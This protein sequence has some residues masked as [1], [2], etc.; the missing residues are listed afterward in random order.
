MKTMV[1]TMILL[2][3]VASAS[4]AQQQGP[5]SDHW[6][7]ISRASSIHVIDSADLKIHVPDME[8]KVRDRSYYYQ[9]SVE[10]TLK[11]ERVDSIKIRMVLEQAFIDRVKSLPDDTGLIIFITNRYAEF[12]NSDADE[13]SNFFLGTIDNKGIIIRTDEVYRGIVDEIRSQRV[14]LHDKLYESFLRDEDMDRKIK[15]LIGELV[16]PEREMAAFDELLKIGK[17]AV[18]YIILH[19]D[20]YRELPI[21]YAMVIDDSPDAF[22]EWVHYGPKLVIDMLGIVLGKL[23]KASFGFIYNGGT[24]E[25]RQRTLNGWRIYLYYHYVGNELNRSNE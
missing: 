5:R 8:N 1:A 12:R 21:K 4:R 20:D 25:E 17:E 23:T 14:I 18:P 11:G 10:E 6:Q 13:F 22:E 16:I 9:I 3:A 19:M 15:G 2:A 7:F 24:N